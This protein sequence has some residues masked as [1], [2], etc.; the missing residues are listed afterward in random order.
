MTDNL[1][2]FG[3]IYSAYGCALN[4]LSEWDELEII[5]GLNSDVEASLR[6]IER[7]EN[8]V[9]HVDRAA[10]LALSVKIDGEVNPLSPRTRRNILNALHVQRDGKFIAPVLSLQKN[11]RAWHISESQGE[12][13]YFGE[14]CTHRG[15]HPDPERKGRVSSRHPNEYHRLVSRRA[16]QAIV[17]VVDREQLVTPSLHRIYNSIPDDI[18]TSGERVYSV[19]ESI[20]RLKDLD[21]EGRLRV[22]RELE[23]VS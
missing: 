6:D 12:C 15:I 8:T 10:A 16:K 2:A 19:D 13:T 5:D 1:M 23:A 18:L 14:V 22:I 20:R 11:N 9:N 4:Y 3:S 17:S 7:F 21:L